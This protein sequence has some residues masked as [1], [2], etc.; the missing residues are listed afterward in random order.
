MAETSAETGGDNAPRRSVKSRIAN[1]LSSNPV[2]PAWGLSLGGLV[3]GV[4]GFAAGGLVLPTEAAVGAGV[5]AILVTAIGLATPRGLRS[6]LAPLTGLI[7]L[8]ALFLA[9]LATG[10]PLVSGLAMGA[11]MFV[12][13]ISSAGGKAIGVIG[14]VLGTAYFIPAVVGYTADISTPDTILQGIIGVA[15]GLVT[16]AL[17]ARFI[18]PL[19]TPPK[20]QPNQKLDASNDSGPLHA[21]LAAARTRSPL[22]AYAVRRA[23]VVGIAVGIYQAS[24][25]HNVFWVALTL[26]AVLSPDESSTWGKALNRSVGTIAGA[27]LVGALAQVLE[28]QIMIGIG[29]AALIV[30]ISFMQ[31]NYAVYSAGMAMLIVALFGASDNQFF[32]WAG[33]RILDTGIG[34][35]IA[36]ASLYLLPYRDNDGPEHEKGLQ[37]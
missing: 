15:A 28:P 32:E 21:M 31:R 30:G 35:A 18:K 5:T 23:I 25:S 4:L 36:I 20:Q 3:G 11:V 17:L 33:L 12:S 37:T 22:R 1:S 14:T 8:V 24:G 2:R 19:E 29:A 16:V 7:T 9:H 6:K 26:F 27:L 34:V 13:A 10:S